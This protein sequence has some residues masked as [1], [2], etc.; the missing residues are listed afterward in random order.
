M[1][2]GI[3]SSRAGIANT[4]NAES[5]GSPALR[6]AGARKQ[7]VPTRP[8]PWLVLIGAFLA[9]AA[10]QLGFSSPAHADHAVD[11]GVYVS[12]TGT[13]HNRDNDFDG[14]V[15]GVGR[16][17]ESAQQFRTGPSPN[18]D[19]YVLGSIEAQF[20]IRV[21][22]PG[23]LTVRLRTTN[24]SKRPGNIVCTL[25]NPPVVGPGFRRFKATE[26][27]RLAPNTDY[28]VH[29]HF[30][31]DDDVEYTSGPSWLRT[32]LDK[33]D[34]TS[35][36]WSIG[37]VALQRNRDR[38][39]L[40]WTV[41]S[42]S[43]KIRV[44]GLDACPAAPNLSA[45]P[46]EDEV[47]LSWTD[48]EDSTITKYQYR[49]KTGTGAYGDWSAIPDSASSIACSGRNGPP[50]NRHRRTPRVSAPCRGRRPRCLAL[51]LETRPLSP[52]PPGEPP[53]YSS[54]PPDQG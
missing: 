4:A 42:S 45:T 12:N 8:F 49:Q 37:N 13:G 3:S 47:M 32:Y 28:F 34:V 51:L 33:E 54:M 23:T 22:S 44:L 40:P 25:G 30:L 29:L 10:L 46:G 35:D 39:D 6:R 21:P 36:G 20:G 27:P 9:A 41:W 31:E 14:G 15:F 50:S 52:E 26:C 17:L 5:S 2:D 38:V 16:L 53:R 19:G 18:P 1:T 43:L 24:A 11:A 48:P 7:T